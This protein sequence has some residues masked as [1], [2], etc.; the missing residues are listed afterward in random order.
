MEPGGC[1]WWYEGEWRRDVQRVPLPQPVGRMTHQPAPALSPLTTIIPSVTSPAHKLYAV[2]S[3][4]EDI[5]LIEAR[6]R[7]CWSCIQVGAHHHCRHWWEQK[8]ERDLDDTRIG[9][10]L[11]H[12][13]AAVETKDA[14]LVAFNGSLPAEASPI[15]VRLL[16]AFWRAGLDP[17][18]QH[19]IA[20]YIVDFAFPKA[21][22]AVEAD[23]EAY[24]QD[25]ERERRRD[26]AIMQQGWYIRHFTGK[27]IWR[28]ADACVAII[29]KLCRADFT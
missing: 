16:E 27:E 3:E 5:A 12:W 7:A 9:R 29:Y 19:G 21:R 8:Q 17:K 26:A 15:E 4:P 14:N 11:T 22:I 20:G 28:D 1:V 24:H 23:G 25:A 13:A 18:Q 2:G 10:T 6:Y